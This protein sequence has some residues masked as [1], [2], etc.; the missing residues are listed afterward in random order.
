MRTPRP[1]HVIF[2]EGLTVAVSNRG[3]GAYLGMATDLRPRGTGPN[4]VTH[5]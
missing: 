5:L 1:L 4:D 3:S 2:D